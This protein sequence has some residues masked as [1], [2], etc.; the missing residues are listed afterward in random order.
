MMCHPN[1][2]RSPSLDSLEFKVMDAIE[3][4]QK[5][6]D[7]QDMPQ[8]GWWVHLGRLLF[9]A[10]EAERVAK[11]RHPLVSS[12]HIHRTANIL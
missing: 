8:K 1:F 2:K 4:T 12:V 10:F 5:K 6:Y 11:Q 9:T 3:E 7:I